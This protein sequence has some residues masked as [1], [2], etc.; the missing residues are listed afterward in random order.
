M[1]KSSG[2]ITNPAVG[3]L[4]DNP[5]LAMSGSIT[6]TYF[7]LIWKTII[8]LGGLLLILYFIWGA[9]DWITSGGDSGKIASARNKIIQAVIGM[10]L[11]AFS[12]VII[13]FIGFLLFG[14]E[15]NIMDLTFLT[16]I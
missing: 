9:V 4:G 10:I 8:N 2:G 15:F 6:L 12:F 5:D 3:A 14:D 7:I 16:I 11:L 13:G 1:P